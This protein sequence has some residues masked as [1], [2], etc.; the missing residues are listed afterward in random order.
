MSKIS[1]ISI[2]APC[3]EIAASLAPSRVNVCGG[4]C[5]EVFPE[6]SIFLFTE[7]RIYES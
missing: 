6:L 5:D 7:L 3:A 4:V 2:E 1:A